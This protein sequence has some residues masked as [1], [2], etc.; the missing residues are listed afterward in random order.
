MS[1]LYTTIYG[2]YLRSRALLA[3]DTRYK[4]YAE[5]KREQW[6]SR[7][8]IENLQRTRL[9]KLL[10]K[11]ASTS[12]YYG[13]RLADITGLDN[14]SFNLSDLHK[15]PLLTRKD[16]QENLDDILCREAGPVEKD[17]TG[18]STGHPV[19]FY[20]DVSYQTFSDACELLFMSWMDVAFGDRTAVFWGA[21]RDFKELSFKERLA[22]NAKR[23]LSLNSFNM[24]AEKLD[25]FL[26]QIEKYRPAYV[27]GYA[28]SLNLAAE[29][30]NTSGAYDIRPRAV[31][32]AAEM[33]YGF[34]RTEIESAFGTQLFN[35]YGS[36]EVSHLGAECSEHTGLHVFSSGRIIE[37][38]DDQGT[39][40][41][42]GKTG[43]LAVTDLTN[44]DFPFI[45]Y[46]NGDM[47]SLREDACPCGR[48][49]HMLDNL[50]GR[51][52]DIICLNGKYIHGE[53]FTHLFYD[54]PE[55]KQFQ[56]VQESADRLVIRI[57]ARDPH[58][59]SEPIL[60]PIRDIVG[61]H[62]DLSIELVNEIPPTKSGKYRFTVNNINSTKA[63]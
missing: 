33:L 60:K 51:S 9:Q 34:Q 56:A 45:R 17:A 24:T 18:G 15:L 62:T 41:P 44:L 40:L 21:D 50:A 47:G 57:V 49:Y 20:H 10:R 7:D 11:A 39:P 28:S 30:I 1:S 2:A 37:V 36:R 43:Y 23:V 32:S 13:I 16:L 46:L 35:F 59:D 22:R 48:G 8:E 38:V 54:R 61:E 25:N 42:P 31:R 4:L 19:N 53:F 14:N 27:I 63:E 52:S 26:R 55:V 29:A 12:P 3:G 6:L 5:L 58:F